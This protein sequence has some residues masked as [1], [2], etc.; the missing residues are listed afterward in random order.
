M[1]DAE[2][3]Q[4]AEQIKSELRKLI[5]C[6]IIDV[7]SDSD[8]HEDYFGVRAETPGGDVFECWLSGVTEAESSG[9]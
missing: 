4:R 1:I 2:A 8:G 3:V 5:G 6:R 9:S 7:L